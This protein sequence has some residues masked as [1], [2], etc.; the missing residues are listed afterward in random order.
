MR[1]RLLY[2]SIHICIYPLHINPYLFKGIYHICLLKLNT[3]TK[4]TIGINLN[5]F[6]DFM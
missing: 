1:I 4:E 5:Q 2:N 3:T 6:Y